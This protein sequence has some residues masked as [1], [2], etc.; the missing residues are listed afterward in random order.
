MMSLPSPMSVMLSRFLFC[1]ASELLSTTGPLH[2]CCLPRVLP[3]SYSPSHHLL[4][5]PF[6]ATPARLPLH[7]SQPPPSSIQQ[8]FQEPGIPRL[9]YDLTLLPSQTSPQFETTLFI[10]LLSI[11]LK[12]NSMGAGIYMFCSSRHLQHTQ[13]SAWHLVGAQLP[14]AEGKEERKEGKGRNGGA[15]W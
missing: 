11:P 12:I 7:S 13:Y 1:K 8:T 10:C 9:S 2:G 6:M 5:G 14:F 3:S 15:F 4:K